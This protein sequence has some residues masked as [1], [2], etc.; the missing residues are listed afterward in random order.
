MERIVY[1]D[2]SAIKTNVRR[3]T[4]RHEWIE[5]PTTEPEQVRPRLAG[6]TIAITH[7][8]FLAGQDLPPTLRL[9][10][11]GSTGFERVDL[12][13]CRAR[14]VH[15]CNVR[16]WSWSVPEHVFALVLA[17]RR[18]LLSYRDAVRAGEWSWTGDPA[19]LAQLIG[20]PLRNETLGVV[21]FGAIGRSVA[22]LGRAFGMTVLIAE[23]KGAPVPRPGRVPFD[24]VLQTSDVLTLHCPLLVETREMIGARELSV[25]KKD[26]LLINCARGGIV[27]E[28]A[29][30][31]ALAAGRIG[32]T[33]I[34]SL[35][36][37]PPSPDNPLL[38]LKLANLI[39]TPHVA[40]ASQGAL[41]NLA[42][43]LIQNI[44]A[45]VHDKPRNLVA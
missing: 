31:N 40:W 45:F 27:D 38:K 4:F 35:A 25:M 34:D 41:A 23:R 2:R 14:G 32:G 36:D 29:L 28:F 5:Y 1:L 24:V 19:R 3:P 8:V 21:G 26:A 7:R 16:D 13:G 39:I 37:E 6:A 43:Q 33:G 42:E 20:R 9:I 15:V 30:A 10:A 17:L 11:V 12:A 44:E 22:Q 18:N